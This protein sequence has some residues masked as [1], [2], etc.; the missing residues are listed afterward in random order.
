MSNPRGKPTCSC[1]MML[2][3]RSPQSEGVR[4]VVTVG[5]L[6]FIADF[7]EDPGRGWGLTVIRNFYEAGRHLIG[8][9]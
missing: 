2:P 9:S 3:S 1:D 6:I 7:A 5:I 4:F 8:V